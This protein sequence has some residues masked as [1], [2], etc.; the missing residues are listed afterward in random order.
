M[1]EPWL[2]PDELI[3]GFA[4]VWSRL[5]GG[6]IVER[7]CAAG[8]LIIWMGHDGQRIALPDRMYGLMSPTQ[9]SVETTDIPSG[10]WVHLPPGVS[11]PGAEP[12]CLGHSL[13]ASSLEEAWAALRRVGRQG[14]DKARRLRCRVEAIT[15]AEYV[16]L[17][18]LKANALGGRPPSPELPEALRDTFGGDKVHLTGVRHDGQPVAAVLAVQVGEYGMLID[19]ASDRAHW[20]KNPNNL[21]VWQAVSSLVSAGCTRVDYGFSP[22]GAGDARFKDHMGGRATE[23]YRV[24][25]T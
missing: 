6:T 11:T 19:G 21:A 7:D 13:E 12:H 3:R 15:D 8:R 25:G 17:A 14:V 9:L 10:L 1:T 20:D 24:L 2:V 5:A 16:E 23:L 4:Q 22:V 18:F